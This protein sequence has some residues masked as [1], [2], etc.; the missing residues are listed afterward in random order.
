MNLAFLGCGRAAAMHSRTLSRERG[1]ALSFAS[2]ARDR[3]EW[4]RHRFS[5]HKAFGAYEDAFRDPAVDVAVITTPTVEHRPLAELALRAG[6][7]VIVEKPAFM[8]VGEADAIRALATH[9][10]RRVF[11]A[12]NYAYKPLLALLRRQISSGMLGDVRFITLDATTRQHGTDWRSDARLSGGGALFEGGVHWVS[13]AASLGLAIRSVHGFRAGP[14][15]GAHES[16]AVILEYECGAVGMLKHSWE[17]EAPLRG[18]R[19]SKVQ[20]TRGAVTFQSHGFMAYC[21]GARKSAHLFVRDPL[22]YRAMFRDFL[23]AL[24]TGRQP[25]FTLD[26]ARRDLELLERCQSR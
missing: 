7:D 24:Q 10:G 19:M 14:G 6:K 21:S 1:V 17:L 18:L 13:F 11:V 4:Y 23:G 15:R 26:M 12:E 20:G 25:R 5:G 22:G 2:R 9:T 3:A 8:T 16:T